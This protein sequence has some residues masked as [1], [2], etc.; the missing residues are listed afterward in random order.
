MQILKLAAK[1]KRLK[2]NSQKNRYERI[3]YTS[4][5]ARKDTERL[6]IQGNG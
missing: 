2:Y 1:L 3:I 6:Y 5:T 4:N